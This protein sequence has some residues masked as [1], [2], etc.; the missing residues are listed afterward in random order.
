M[1]AAVPMSSTLSTPAATGGPNAQLEAQLSELLDE[2]TFKEAQAAQAERQS[3]QWRQCCADV[4]GYAVALEQHVLLPAFGDLGNALAEFHEA[5]AKRDQGVALLRATVTPASHPQLAQAFRLMEAP[6]PTAAQQMRR[7][8]LQSGPAPARLDDTYL[9]LQALAGQTRDLETL[10]ADAAR[11]AR[12]AAGGS[13]SPAPASPT[14]R[15]ELEDARR[16][17]QRAEADAA[18]VRQELQ[19]LRDGGAAGRA[20]SPEQ[21]L[22]ISEQR[23]ATGAALWE[24]ERRLLESKLAAA[25]QQVQQLEK[26]VTGLRA[27][28]KTAGNFEALYSQG[29]EERRLLQERLDQMEGAQRQHDDERQQVALHFDRLQRALQQQQQGAPPGPTAEVAAVSPP[30]PLTSLPTQQLEDKVRRLES[31]RHL[32]RQEAAAKAAKNDKIIAELRRRL[33]ATQQQQHAGVASP[34]PPSGVAA[35]DGT[36][37]RGASPQQQMLVT[38]ATLGAEDSF[39]NPHA[40]EAAVANQTKLKAFEL[41]IAALNDELAQLEQKIVANDAGHQRA[42]ERQAAGFEEERRGYQSELKE[43][44][45]V[46][47]SL[48]QELEQAMNENAVLRQRLSAHQGQTSQ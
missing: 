48:A 8:Q 39:M 43:C 11:Q 47:G 38:A 10:I 37:S 20:E 30:S 19:R 4:V 27:Q 32:E 22:A 46:V 35:A 16:A 12:N 36:L 28:G 33:L 15:Y 14:Q 42:L 34:L 29:V 13:A 21:L 41:T 23:N 2:V 5:K 24:Q 6:G 26:E 3:A 31:Q 45:G 18:A 1:T 44:D 7:Q 25:T 17:Q 40:H 9:A